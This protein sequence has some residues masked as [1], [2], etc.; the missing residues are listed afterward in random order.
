MGD[1]FDFRIVR[2]LPQIGRKHARRQIQIARLFI[3]AHHDRFQ[4]QL[5][6]RMP[7]RPLA[8]LDQQ[9]RHAGADGAH[10][11]D[12]DFGLVHDLISYQLTSH[13]A[14]AE[15]VCLHGENLPC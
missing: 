3:V 1:D 11:D 2:N 8:M 6:P 7:R 10:A 9:P 12:G 15:K 4:H 14:Y 13:R 5:P